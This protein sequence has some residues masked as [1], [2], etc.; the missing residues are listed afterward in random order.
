MRT[1]VAIL[2]LLSAACGNAMDLGT[3]EVLVREAAELE[4]SGDPVGSYR[5]YKLVEGTYETNDELRSEA[6]DGAQRTRAQAEKMAVEITKALNSYRSVHGFYPSKLADVATMLPAE[7]ARVLNRFQA[8]ESADGSM[9][10][11][12]S[13]NGHSF[14]LR[15]R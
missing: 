10:A 9:I 13:L 11:K 15:N 7:I 8:Y 2:C 6:W 12:A 3:A 1:L 4:R 5:K 14:D